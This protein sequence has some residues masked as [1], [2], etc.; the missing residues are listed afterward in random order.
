MDPLYLIVGIYYAAVFA[1]SVGF[2]MWA[3]PKVERFL[4]WLLKTPR[5]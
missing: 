5:A 2:T 3:T 4:R 1:F